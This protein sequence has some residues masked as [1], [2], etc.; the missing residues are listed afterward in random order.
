ME[1]KGISQKIKEY[2]WEN[3]AHEPSLCEISARLGISLTYASIVFKRECAMGFRDYLKKYRIEKACD[4]IRASDK[5][6][7]EISSLVGYSDPAFFYRIFKSHLGVSPG[8][9]KKIRTSQ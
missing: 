9:Y 2:V 6:L 5:T 8:E 1:E 3:Y 7:S 4:L